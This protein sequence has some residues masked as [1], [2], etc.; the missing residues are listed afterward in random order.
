[1][2][3]QLS[4]TLHG[5]VS[6][7]RHKKRETGKEELKIC[8][9]ASIRSDVG[10]RVFLMQGGGGGNRFALVK[11]C[12]TSEK[13]FDCVACMQHFDWPEITQRTQNQIKHPQ[14]KHG[15]GSSKH[16]QT[17]KCWTGLAF[18]C[19]ALWNETAKCQGKWVLSSRFCTKFF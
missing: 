16:R 18:I 9:Y 12:V 1:M 7:G 5:L 17:N 4:F 8:Q 10:P 19:R 13:M 3:A 11:A 15:F 6:P 2:L 14:I